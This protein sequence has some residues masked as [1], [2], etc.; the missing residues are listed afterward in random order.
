MLTP[1]Q[2][3]RELVLDE[4]QLLAMVNDGCLPAYD[5]G[6]HVRFKVADVAALIGLIAV[7]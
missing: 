7:A 6:G 3:C 4:Q 2:V 1:S 5:L